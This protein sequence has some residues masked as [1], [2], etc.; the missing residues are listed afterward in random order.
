MF[1]PDLDLDFLPIPDPG[2]KKAPDPD[3]QHWLHIGSWFGNYKS[4]NFH[5]E[6]ADNKNEFVQNCLFN[7][8]F[9]FCAILLYYFFGNA[10]QAFMLHVM[11]I[12][13]TVKVN[14]LLLLYCR[15]VYCVYRTDI[16]VFI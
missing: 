12:G 15:I 10:Q 3:P 11:I 6:Y 1:V 4:Q 16:I 9:L 13:R 7:L 2:F 14:L 5:P 8:D